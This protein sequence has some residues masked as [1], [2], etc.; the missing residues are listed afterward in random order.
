MIAE[1]NE[2]VLRDYFARLDRLVAP[3]TELF[4]F[5]GASI[6]L[7]GSKIR[8]TVDVDV[9]APYSRVDMVSFKEASKLAGLPVNPGM[10]YQGA[11]LEFVEERMLALPV[12]KRDEATVLFRG[13]NL[14]VITASESDLVASKLV[15]YND[16]D[17]SDVQFLAG[18]G[19]VSPEDVKA[20]VARMSPRL[21]SDVLVAENLSNLETDF[22]LWKE[23]S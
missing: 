20:S 5:G 1:I 2:Q 22:M 3:G 14:T 7:L 21:R 17:R 16:K 10:G 15:R 9:A 12:Q 19:K 4:V 8:T 6:A 13:L 23:I 11:Y 18:L